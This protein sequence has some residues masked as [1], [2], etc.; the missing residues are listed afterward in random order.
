MSFT[1]FTCVVLQKHMQL[2]KVSWLYVAVASA[3]HFEVI[4]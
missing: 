1:G 4:A 2:I 3:H